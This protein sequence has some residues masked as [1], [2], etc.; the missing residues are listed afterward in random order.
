MSLESLLEQLEAR[1]AVTP[2]T[3]R[4][5]AGVTA[6]AANSAGCTPVTPVTP[7]N[8]KH[9]AQTQ[10]HC[11]A[12]ADDA[13]TIDPERYE[14]VEFNDWL[15]PSGRR[16]AFKLAIPKERHDGFELIRILE[17]RDAAARVAP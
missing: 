8:H 2:V 5:A 17:R 10:P 4:N 12:A 7:K 15:L 11:N 6:K 9:Q 16:V 14:I 1:P 13:Q 3:P